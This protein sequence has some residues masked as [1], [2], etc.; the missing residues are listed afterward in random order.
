MPLLSENVKQKIDAKMLYVVKYKKK[1][2]TCACGAYN[3]IYWHKIFAPLQIGKKSKNE[4]F[5][6]EKL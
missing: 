6:S 5:P 1:I 3:V 4:I 2:F